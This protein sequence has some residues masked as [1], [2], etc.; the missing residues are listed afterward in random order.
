MKQFESLKVGD[1]IYV[2]VFHYTSTDWYYGKVTKRTK[3]R[4][5]VRY[6]NRDRVFSLDGRPYPRVT[7]LSHWTTL[8]ELTEANRERYVRSQALR[9]INNRHTSLGK[10]FSNK[11]FMSKVDTMVL[12]RIIDTLCNIDN[13]LIEVKF[14][15]EHA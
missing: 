1:G 13:S 2:E 12:E 10:F 8:A 5:T 7:G 6:D 14:D 3:T 4:L 9:I 11:D 15:A